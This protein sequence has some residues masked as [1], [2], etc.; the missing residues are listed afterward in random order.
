[1]F[2]SWIVHLKFYSKKEDIIFIFPKIFLPSFKNDDDTSRW[3]CDK[4]PYYIIFS[5][6][7]FENR[8]MTSPFEKKRIPVT[9]VTGYLGS[10]KTTLLNHI[11]NGNHGKKFAVIENE[12]G[13]V[14]VDDGLLKRRSK[15]SLADEVIEMINGTI[16][17]IAY[18]FYDLTKF[19]FKSRTII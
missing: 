3:M 10:G 13:A 19:R 12:F 11:L 18:A 5:C 7:Y 15:F 2:S 17:I 4:H 16:I 1:M 9:I 8:E 14:G 6:I